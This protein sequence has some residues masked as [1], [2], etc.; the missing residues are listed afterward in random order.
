[1]SR[2]KNENYITI[3]GWM[4]NE[5]NLKG[6]ELIIYAV[7][8]GFSQAENQ[9]YNGSLQYLADWTNSTKQGVSKNLKSLVD[10]GFLAK[11]EKIINNVKFC[12]YYATKFNTPVNNVDQGMQQS[13]MGGMQQSLPN[14]IDNISTINNNKKESKKE[15]KKAENS[16]DRLISKYLSDDGYADSDKRKELLQEWLK[17]RKAKRAAM[18]DR[19][20]ELNL[21]KLNRLA[22]E[23][24]MSVVTYLEE[25]IAR[26]WASF[27]KINNYNNNNNSYK[28][29]REEIVPDWFNQKI[30][31]EP[32]DSKELAELEKQL[33][34]F[35]QDEPEPTKQKKEDKP[36]SYQEYLKSTEQEP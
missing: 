1:M 24:K 5:L 3:Q 16:F 9:T 33:A 18:T 34:C 10:K 35:K 4:I 17:V 26:G 31:A 32:M 13:L 25:V 15:S 30:E 36:I 8:Y 22:S 6:N 14:N 29:V 23:S 21:N 7:I 11:N 20:I 27:F 28:P 12:E 19:A 2:I